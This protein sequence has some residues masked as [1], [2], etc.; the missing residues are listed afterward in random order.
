[1]SILW[2]IVYFIILIGVLVFI[3]EGGHFILAKLFKVKVHTFSLGFGPKLVGFTK[4][5][6]LYKI[7]AVPI[8][9]YVKMLGEDP[10][11]EIA[12]EDRGRAFT[13]KA[14]WKRFLIIAGGPAM[15]LIFPFILHFAVGLTHT[16][17]LPPTVGMVLPGSPAA[18]AGLLPGDEVVS[19]DGRE[20]GTFDDMVAIVEPNPGVPLAFVVRRGGATFGRTISPRPTAVTVVLSE[21]DVVGKIGVGPSYIA[22]VIGVEDPGSL[23]AGAGLMTFDRIVEVDGAPVDRMVDLERV[24]VGAAGREVKIAYHRMKPV[25]EPTTEDLY[26]EE[27]STLRMG[28]PAGTTS[29]ADLGIADSTEFVVFVDPKGAAA[30]VGLKRGDRLLTLDG[31]SHGMG[32]IYSVIDEDPARER[33]LAWSSGGERRSARFKPRFIPAGEAKDLGVANDVYDKGFWGYSRGSAPEKIPNPALVAS[34]WRNSRTETWSGFRMIGIGFKLLFRGDVSMRS[35]GGP[36]MIGQLA[37]MAGEQGAASFIWMMALISLNLGLL[38]LLPIPVLDGGQ[39]LFLGVEA[40]S[41]RK[42]DRRIKER[43]MLVGLAMIVMLMLFATWNDIAR[44]FV[45]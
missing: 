26:G 21:K 44:L 23:A 14:V 39:I 45:Q 25:I 13:D 37:G 34:A 22:S 15:N 33:E 1:M 8:G 9:G 30:E 7:S 29:L 2:T 18:E 32:Q 41:R 40:V 3:H 27:K 20:V 36:I 42:V 6:T 43:V 5:E 31:S 12:E 11:E 17:A 24:L 16:E 19:V 4:G 10:T 38:N 35:I 28:I